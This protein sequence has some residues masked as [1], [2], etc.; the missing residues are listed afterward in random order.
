MPFLDHLE[1][2][3]WR[4]LRAL[5]ALAAGAVLGYVI[6]QRFGVMELLVRPARSILPNG[7]LAVL[8]PMTPFFLTLKLAVVVGIILAFPFIV[9]EVWGFLAP[10]LKPRERRVIVPS[11]YFGLVLF[12][13]GVAM[14]YFWVLPLALVFGMSFQADYLVAMIEATQYLR[15]VTQLLIAFGIVF[16][17]PVVVMILSFLGLVTPKFLRD[18]RRHAIVAITIVASVVTPGD[19]ISTFMMLG[20]LL[21]LFELS[22]LISAVIHRRKERAERE[23]ELMPVNDPPSG[24]IG[25][26]GP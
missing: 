15:F 12:C 18:K 3:R 17:L 7:E 16:E 9:R 6:V 23:A 11:L 20:P 24:T 14:A 10:G 4:L 8:N 1:E 26:E 25:V 19:L 5:A 13:V 22:I 21:V 2:L